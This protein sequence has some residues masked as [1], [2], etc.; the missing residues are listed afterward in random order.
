[1]TCGLFHMYVFWNL[2][3]E[4][5]RMVLM[6]PHLARLPSPWRYFNLVTR[7]LARLYTRGNAKVYY[8]YIT[9][10]MVLEA[11]AKSRVFHIRRMIQRKKKLTDY[12]KINYENRTY[13]VSA[14]TDSLSRLVISW[15]QFTIPG[16]WLDFTIRYA[17]CYCFW[18]RHRAASNKEPLDL[19]EF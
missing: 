11:A 10:E 14:L 16:D 2:F 12:R 15:C 5:G 4:A 3:V 9:N 13:F 7:S 8:N 18:M 19:E 1:V 17:F 6:R